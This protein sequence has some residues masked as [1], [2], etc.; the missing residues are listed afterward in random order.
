[1]AAFAGGAPDARAIVLNDG[2][3]LAAGGIANYFDSAN[4]FPNVVELNFLSPPGS[5]NG[6]ICTGTLINSR[7]ILTA[8]HCV[9]GSNNIT[10]TVQPGSSVYFLPL[11]S[12][13]PASSGNLI[14]GAI[15]AP[16]YDGAAA[17]LALV[18]LANPVPNIAPV[19]LLQPGN[20]L[21]QVGA[22]VTE[23]GFGSSGTGTTGNPGNDDKR[24][25]GQTE[26]GYY[27]P[28]NASP[29]PND[30]AQP[31]FQAQFRN[32][33]SPGNPDIFGL[34]A[35][36]IAT[37]PLE[38]GVAPGDSGGP[39]FWTNANGQV[40]EI[41]EVQSGAGG[42]PANGYGETNS[43]TPVQVFSTFITQNNPLRQI[44]SN[45]GNFNWSNAAAWT[46]S[47][48]GGP[49]PIVPN[50]TNGV[51]GGY[52]SVAY[53]YNVALANAGAITT[54]ISP[55][56]D[57]LSIQGAQSQLTI[58]P[59][60][61]LTT[62][63]SAQMNAGTLLVNGTLALPN[64][65][66]V[67]GTTATQALALN[68]GLLGGTGTI[69]ASGGVANTAANIA[70]G[71]GAAPGTLTIQGSYTQ[72]T[73]GTLTIQLAPAASSQLA[74]GG[75]ASLAGILQLAGAGPY[76]IG[77]N[78]TILTATSLT[79][80]F[81]TVNGSQLT[82][83][84]TATPTYLPTA[85]QLSVAQNVSFT[86]AAT[87]P[88]QIAVAKA[89]DK[90][91]VTLMGNLLT[92]A[93]DLANSTPAQ[94][95][96]GLN[97]LAADGDGS[98]DGDVV[99]NYL[100]GNLAAAEIVGRALDEHIAMLRG[101]DD[102]TLAAA[103]L[104][105]LQ[106]NFASRSPAQFAEAFGG[107][108][109]AAA[110][111]APGSVAIPPVKLWAQGIGAWQNLRDDGETPGMLQAIGG[112]IAG[113]DMR[114]FAETLPHLKGG[115][116][117]SYTNGSL[118]GD[119]ESGSTNAY[120]LAL[121]AT[122][123]W[124]AAFV[125]G[126]AGYGYDQIATS[127]FV[128]FDALDQTATGSTYGYEVSTRLAAGY[129]LDFGRVHLEPSAAVAYDRVTRSGYTENGAG[130]IGLMVSPSAL[131]SLRLSF[132]ARAG[133][134]IDLGNGLMLRPAV[135]ARFEDHVLS[136]L[137]T[138]NLAF[139]GAPDDPFQIVGAQPGRQAALLDGGFTIGNG[140]CVA[141]FADYTADLR[142]HE[143][144]QAVVGGVRITW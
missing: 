57:S 60:T 68:G 37:L 33:L 105:G 28:G 116:A 72:T 98:S 71:S 3:A 123:S 141:A 124:G 23:V 75:A 125:E 8:A 142:L 30:G 20:T 106:F 41:G 82:A 53:Y 21:P 79:G 14:T 25:V 27:G 19:T 47:V 22:T 16:G 130:D 135:E 64:L 24:R 67:T 84:L 44:S 10:N 93:N 107:D 18:S 62:L 95:A 99:G 31:F 120:R 85:V 97:Q 42:T 36:G 140:G 90:T 83:F 70:P 137:P 78:Y 100:T 127:R 76:K 77:F 131:D 58:A 38:A 108:T 49:A 13:G 26:L 121:Y 122:N 118:M 65:A 43:W 138:T 59:S 50:N 34:N 9:T 35:K 61:T 89:L 119:D 39:L 7:T 46:D 1:V 115:V 113:V 96:V 15:R 101:D 133:T 132:G 73:N 6:S 103:G 56:I 55:T 69:T 126:R 143:T 81:G 11:G 114:P 4:A 12:N 94:V 5:N 111:A 66:L 80:A 51:V 129:G 17:D 32:P 109:V 91:G 139:I 52:L 110:D 128:G 92:A 29:F 88:N 54:D 40:I 117:F 2:A 45:A 104:H 102:G 136:E 74:V 87:T 144:V 63:V 86:T 48:P 112:V 134:S